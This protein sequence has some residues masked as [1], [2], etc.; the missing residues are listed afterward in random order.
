MHLLVIG[1][2]HKTAPLEARERAY[3]CED[4]LG[5]ILGALQARSVKESVVLS[6]CN[7]TEIYSTYES[8]EETSRAIEDALME[9]F[10]V[11]P[12]WL[13]TYTYTF[14][15]EQAYG[16]L[17]FV[18]SG[19]D[20]MVLGE[21]QILGQV[22]DFYRLARL[23]NSVGPFLDKVF[24]RA[25][26]VAKKV[27]TDT[28][29]GYNPVSISSMAI[30]LARKIFGDL[31]QKKILVIGAGEMCE[32][33][34]RRFKKEGLREIFITNRTFHKAEQ[35]AEEIIGIPEP[36]D[37][38]P[39]LL[40]RVDMVLSSTGAP[41][42]IIERHQIAA[43]MKRRK[44]RPLF[45]IDIAVPRDVEPEVNQIENVYLYDIDD[46]R[47]LSLEHLA[48]RA[49]E[50]EKARAII[51]EEVGRFGLWLKQ[52]DMNPI[53]THILDEVEE[54]R[55]HEVNKG[56]QKMPGCDEAVAKQIDIVTRAI[57]NKLVHPHI[58]MLR[59][60]GSALVVDIIKG[61]FHF[62][63]L[64]NYADSAKEQS[65]DEGHKPA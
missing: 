53:I 21:P 31:R 56:L 27:R 61:L 7:R 38:I 29:I 48:D 30:E 47:G 35:L 14:T 6:T 24:N 50:A 58:E 40:T 44:Y 37:E 41:R 36:Y 11:G 26:Q 39:E 1:L 3:V 13:R 18:V 64:A 43:V 8:L 57:V 19:L 12:E 46:L 34:L 55:K 5:D 10:Q 23:S 9:H 15:D 4:N 65:D 59:K 45:F 2:N 25:F 60:D 33:A 17:F 28:K 20:S 62:G 32:V 49:Q 51:E 54:I 42:P 63:G 52:L 16:H 22:K